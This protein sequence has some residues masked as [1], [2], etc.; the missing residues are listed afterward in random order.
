[1]IPISLLSILFMHY[2]FQAFK[3]DISCIV[4]DLGALKHG[5][6]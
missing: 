6:M 3:L 4:H 1:M 5:M 2:T